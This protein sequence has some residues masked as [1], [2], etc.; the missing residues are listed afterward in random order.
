MTFRI[1]E[2]ISLKGDTLI[3][4]LGCNGGGV[5]SISGTDHGLEVKGLLLK[6]SFLMPWLTTLI[7]DFGIWW[8]WINL[9]DL[10]GDNAMG[11]EGPSDM[12]GPFRLVDLEASG[13]CANFSMKN[14]DLL[15]GFETI[16]LLVLD[17]VEEN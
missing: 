8:V 7:G 13:G 12:M 11:V 3:P 1:I 14:L 17:G 9:G 5:L 4:N 6:D 16:R 10:R 15:G 2:E